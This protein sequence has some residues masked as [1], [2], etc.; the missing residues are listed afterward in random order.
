M[1]YQWS[2]ETLADCAN[3]LDAGNLRELIAE[4][5]EDTLH[6]AMGVLA[7][8]EANL[9]ERVE[10]ENLCPN[11][12]TELQVKTKLHVSNNWDEPPGSWEEPDG[13]GCAECGWEG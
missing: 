5:R 4:L 9:A 8:L 12:L 13:E 6:V 11:C 10:R 2:I 1:D 3:G 7:A